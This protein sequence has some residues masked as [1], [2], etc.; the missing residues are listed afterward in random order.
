VIGSTL[1]RLGRQTAVYGFGDL[2]VKSL[3]FLLIPVFTRVWAVDGPEMG[4]YGLLHLAEAVSYLF[5]NLGLATAVI[6]VLADYHHGRARGSVVY[7]TLIL[8]GTL[9]VGLL[10]LGWMAARWLAPL[11]FGATASAAL[12]GVGLLRLTLLATYLSTYRFVAY[13]LLRVEGRP[14]LYTIFNV[15][16]F[17]VYVGTAIYL[18]VVEELGVQGIVYANLTASVV[19]LALS[20]GLLQARAKRP[21]SPRKA[22]NLL[23]FG[24]PLLPNGLALWALALLD[25]WLL[26]VLVPVADET[27]RLAVTGQYD[28]AYRFGMIVSFLVVIPLRTAWVPMLFEVRDHPEAPVLYGRL[29]TWVLAL[30]CALA[31][32]LGILAPEIIGVVAGPDWLAAAAPLPLIAFG[33]VAYGASQVADAGILAR[34]RTHLYPLVTLSSVLVNAGL[35][36]LLIPDHGLVGAA[37]ATLI[38]YAW[39]AVMVG[40]VSWGVFPF[41]VETRRLLLVV[42]VT[43]VVF[44]VAAQVPVDWSLPV[45]VGAK[46]G[47]WL[48]YPLALALAGFLSTDERAGLRRLRAGRPDGPSEEDGSLPEYPGLDEDLAS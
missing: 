4:L 23:A 26:R 34:A 19:M 10:A 17:V 3:S 27:A 18:V 15:V 37:W 29:L 24:L 40:R 1:H 47:V 11:L 42:A 25:R 36:I 30:G 28:V 13:S 7:T 21:F 2:L 46:L 44:F 45:R 32:G 39:H 14:W 33:Y 16:N 22:G 6:K 8:L 12:D 9:S 38:A 43:V 48:L 41:R 20:V 5:F 35:C 31:L